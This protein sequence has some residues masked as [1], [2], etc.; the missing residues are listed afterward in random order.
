M[1]RAVIDIGSNS[2]RLFFEGQKDKKINT[3]Q[4]AEGLSFIR[5]LKYEPM[6]RTAKAIKEFYDEARLV[7]DEVYVFATEAVRSAQ[8]GQNFIKM[9]E[10]DY[11]IKI[12]LLSGEKEALAG[13]LGASQGGRP[14]VIDIGGASTEVI[15]GE[16]DKIKYSKSLPVGIV[17]LRDICGNNR[18][19]LNNYISEKIKEY[20]EIKDYDYG[21]AIGGTAST[22]VAILQEGYDREKVHNYRLTR[23]EL[24]MVLH[25][26]DTVSNISMVKGLP[27]KRASVIIGGILMLDHLMEKLSLDEI[28]V[29]EEDNME[30]YLKILSKNLKK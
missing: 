25:K 1:K 11:N 3:T 21:I 14:V 26:L 30:G 17:R 10:D 18:N 19:K 28:I 12:D 2:V 6:E 20:G 27:K 9:M 8:N 16:A 5:N 24:N 23:V 13:Y 4:L 15:V 29:S 7:A 22:V